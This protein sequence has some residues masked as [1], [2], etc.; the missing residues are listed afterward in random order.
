MS[1]FERIRSA[2]RKEPPIAPP[3]RNRV[4]GLAWIE[5]KDIPGAQV[6]HGRVVCTVAMGADGNWQLDPPQVFIASENLA[7][8]GKVYPAG[9]EVRV[10]G[11]RDNRLNPIDAPGDEEQDESARWL[12]PV[13]TRERTDA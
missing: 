3:L 11:A 1:L 6:L 5:A 8:R 9:T 4:G 13:P 7:Y 10:L 2:L 12:P